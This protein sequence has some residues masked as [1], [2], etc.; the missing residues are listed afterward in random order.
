[1]PDP[2]PSIVLGVDVGGTFTDFLLLRDGHLE[3]HKRPSTPDDPARAILEGL[4]A[5]G[6]RPDLLVH[7]STVATN[8]VLERRGARTALITTEGFRDLLLI[9]RQARPDLYDLEPVTPA[10]LVRRELCFELHGRLRPD[11][12]VE[13]APDHSE[14]RNLVREAEDA[15]VE[16]LAVSLLYSYANSTLEELFDPATAST[17]LYLSL[18]S[19]VSPEYREVER[20]ATTALNAY[21]GPVMSRYLQ[22]LDQVLEER[23]ATQLRV[24]QSDGGAADVHRAASLPVATLLSG[25]AAG[26]AGAFAIAQRAGFN[27][28]LTFDMGGTST[29]VALCDG[30]VP[31]RAE[32]T[33]DGLTARTTA[34]DVHTVGAGGGSIARL[35]AGGALRVGPQ[36]AG[37]DPGPAAYGRGTDF[38]VTDA[39]VILGRLGREGLLGGALPLDERRAR[40]AASGLVHA[41]GGD[42]HAAAQAVIDVA[43]ANMERALRVVSVQRGYD[44]RDFTLVAYGGAGP[45]HACALAEALGLPRVVIP[46]LPGVLAAFGAAT[47]DLT[48]T[49]ARSVLLPLDDDSLPA[50]HAALGA[51]SDE[52]KS[53][54]GGAATV[55]EALDLRYAG[56]SYELTVPV[57]RPL[58]LAAVRDA[59]DALH[60]ARF[61]HSDPSSPVEVVNARSTARV[62]GSAAGFPSPLVGEVVLPSGR[63]DEGA[64]ASAREPSTP[65]ETEVERPVWYNGQ[66][67][68]ARVLPRPALAP[69]ARIA[70]PALIT[71]LDSTTLVAPGWAGSVDDDRNLLLE[72]S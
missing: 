12:S 16:A 7:G 55:A 66:R 60:E 47:S 38:T 6:A 29:D 59:F 30:A 54:V 64:P 25:P 71:Q 53:Q 11:G 24:V 70:G 46:A 67:L 43:T 44:P 9:G 17:D 2:H 63:T 20:T 39:Q 23:G 36:S 27:R 42:P 41:F 57:T 56:Q 45:L 52:S 48:A 14:I 4:D 21:V 8:T 69:G 40:R 62:S 31:R 5:L 32:V 28:I 50:L 18:S 34:V 68:P 26:V 10:P 51:A 49:H 13:V 1:L 65:Y 33:I 22:R 58:D 37:A 3:V 15:G 35:D 72:R 19:R 61:A